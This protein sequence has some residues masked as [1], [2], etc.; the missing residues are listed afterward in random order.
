KKI[1]T[2]IR[3]T[4][5][6]EVSSRFIGQL[7]MR[8]LRSLNYIAYVRYASVYKD[9]RDITDLLKFM[10]PLMDAPP[11]EDSKGAESEE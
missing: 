5:E 2:E 3:D 11:A 1:E 10:K 4:H 7:I 6:R 8:E 9:I